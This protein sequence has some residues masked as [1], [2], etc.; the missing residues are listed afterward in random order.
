MP[1]GLVGSDMLPVLGIVQLYAGD[2]LFAVQ[3]VA[4][5]ILLPDFFEIAK[6]IV[7][8]SFA[9]AFKAMSKSTLLS[10]DRL[11]PSEV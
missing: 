11:S 2:F 8:G 9:A 1:G 3:L 5:A 7:T 4:F 10:S 6:S